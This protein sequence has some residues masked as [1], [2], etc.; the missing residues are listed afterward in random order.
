MLISAPSVEILTKDTIITGS[1]SGS[2]AKV[3]DFNS[4]TQLLKV[5]DMTNMFLENEPVTFP[6]GGT[7]KIHAFNPFTSRGTKSGEGFI[8]KGTTSDTGVYRDSGMSI[9]DS[10]FYQS[11][12]YVVR[13]GE[14]IN[15]FRSIVK[16]LVHP[17]GHI[18]FGEVA[19]TNNVSMNVGDA[20]HVRFRP[21][22][23]INGWW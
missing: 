10:K 11:H 4:N 12:S 5:Q 7:F 6:N 21:T 23:V 13:I 19:V 1:V 18:F 17:A 16:D 15:K 9:T 3:L 2:T 20:D 14:S 8:N 22:I